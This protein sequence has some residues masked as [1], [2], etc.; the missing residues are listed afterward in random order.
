MM[1]PGDKRRAGLFL[2]GKPVLIQ[3]LNIV[4]VP[5][6][7]T[8]IVMFGEDDFLF[9]TQ[10]IA[11]TDEF[12]QEIKRG[13]SELDIFSNFQLLMTLVR[14]DNN[15]HNIIENF[16]EFIFPDYKV[17][18]QD[19]LIDFKI[20]QD[21]KERT[22]SRINPFNYDI[23]KD[24]ISNLFLNQT[25]ME[26]EIEYNPAND[27]AKQIA[28]KIKAG[29]KKTKQLKS[30]KGKDQS[31]FAQICSSLSI[32]L[33]MDINIFFNY[34]PFQLYD[35]YSRFFLKQAYDFYQKVSTTPLMDT[36]KMEVPEE[37]TKFNY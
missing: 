26:Q 33:Q 5:P 31:M 29:R 16:L 10:L 9:A 27:A 8:N 36:S 1:N 35:I 34:T 30:E 12:V 22:I 18:F 37:W 28:D 3:D 32:G 14:E 2:S 21:E 11:H 4:I 6:T 25:I 15:I 20:V 7:I 24:T 17:V 13:N 23:L 19:N